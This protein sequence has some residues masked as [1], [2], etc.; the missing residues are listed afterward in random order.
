MLPLHTNVT[1]AATSNVVSVNTE[2]TGCRCVTVCCFPL[3]MSALEVKFIGDGDVLEHIVDKQEGTCSKVCTSAAEVSLLMSW[4]LTSLCSA[5]VVTLSGAPSNSGSV[6]KMVTFKSPAGRRAREHGEQEG[7]ENDVFDEQ[8]YIQ[9][10][11]T[12]NTE[13]E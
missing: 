13:G 1:L 5:R 7:D 10:L 9:A 3:V 6:Q 4:C 11:G 8:N 2:H 12:D